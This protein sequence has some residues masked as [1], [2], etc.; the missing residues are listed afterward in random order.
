MPVLLL[1]CAV[2]F[3]SGHN[4]VAKGMIPYVPPLSFTFIR[5][6]LASLIILPFSWSFIRND[7]AIARKS[8]KR[9]L[10]IAV[11]GISAF[12]TFLYIALQTTTAINVGLISSIFPVTIALFS[13][14]ILKIKLNKLQLLAML[15]CF[16][17]VIVIIFKGDMSFLTRLVFVEGDLWMLAGVFCGALYPVLLHKKPD[18]HGFS[19]LTILIL[20]G[21]LVSFPLFL[22]DIF[23]GD[24]IQMNQQVIVGLFY[25]SIFPSLLSYMFW[26]RGIEMVGA[27]R[28]GLYLNLVPI[29]TAIMAYVFI[30][31][32]ISWYHYAGLMMI[33][34]GMILFNLQ[35]LYIRQNGR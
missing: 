9:L 1:F 21:T 25:I 24:Y 23:M 22:F 33:I 34:S 28:A 35:N 5:W 14:L 11:T 20:F 27:N 17:G 19:L 29:L 8:W 15:V 4:V 3:W 16:I 32:I 12:N 18:I 26:N 31:E 6:M 30:D 13:F 2:L 7:W 10:L